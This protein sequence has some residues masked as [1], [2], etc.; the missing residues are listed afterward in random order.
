MGGS[1][2]H[3][4]YWCVL[5]R[6]TPAELALRSHSVAAS[7]HPLC[8]FAVLLHNSYSHVVDSI[9]TSYMMISR[10]ELISWTDHT[11]RL[12]SMAGAKRFFNTQCVVY[13]RMML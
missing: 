12:H 4:L 3:V 5:D 2:F 1:A 10:I 6:P 13:L 7:T 9:N 11:R 8:S